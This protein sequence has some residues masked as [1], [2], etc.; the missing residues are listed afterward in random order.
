M[1]KIFSIAF[2]R[3]YITTKL[4]VCFFLVHQQLWNLF[5]NRNKLITLYHL[6][7]KVLQYMNVI[8]VN[9]KGL[10]AIVVCES[11]S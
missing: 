5:K 9:N 2:Y 11:R 3:C 8:S 10:L 7:Y 4:G 6:L 1:I